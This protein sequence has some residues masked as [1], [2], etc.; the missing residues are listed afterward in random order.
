LATPANCRARLVQWWVEFDGTNASAVPVDVEFQRA[1]A[2]VTTATT[3]AGNAMDLAEGASLIVTKHSTTV[4]GA[5]TLSG[6]ETHRVHPTSGLL[7]QYPLGREWVVPV[8][9]F[10]R[11][12]A[13][14]AAA[15]NATCGIQW[16][17]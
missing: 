1:S 12:R 10:W 11:L 17:E 5:G 16:E 14:A 13:T 9:A 6:G 4:E 7:M 3:L 2:A 15:V 8:N